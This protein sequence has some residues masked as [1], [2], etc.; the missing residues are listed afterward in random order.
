MITKVATLTL[1]LSLA[2]AAPAAADTHIVHLKAKGCANCLVFVGGTNPNDSFDGFSKH[3][4]L[5]KGR[6]EVLI[7]ARFTS[8]QYGI[9]TKK[10]WTGKGGQA[11]IVPQYQDYFAGEA[12]SNKASKYALKGKLCFPNTLPE[13]T[14]AFTVHRDSGDKGPRPSK[15]KH[16]GDWAYWTPFVLRAWASPTVEGLG[17]WRNTPGGQASAQ[18]TVCGSEYE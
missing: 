12:I 6:G 3:V 9:A 5:H 10:G 8:I 13:S 15:K 7:A 2:V 18:N 14:L 4:Q 16:P 17:S 11:V 1:G